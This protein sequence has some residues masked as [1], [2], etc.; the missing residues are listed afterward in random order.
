MEPLIVIIVVVLALLLGL[1]LGW[2]MGGKSARAGGEATLQLRSMLDAV[3]MERDGAKDRLARLETSLD[4]RERSFDEQ[5]LVLGEA[6]DLLSAQ[7]GE[8]GQKLLG[9][10]QAAFLQRA[11]ERFN[12]AGDKNEERLK[13]LLAPV[14]DRL[15]AYE[16]QV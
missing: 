16:E 9:E 5:K 8:I 12:Q 14:G 11:D 15:K 2:V 13:Q 3:V 1:A 7:F 6:K 4:E 10:A